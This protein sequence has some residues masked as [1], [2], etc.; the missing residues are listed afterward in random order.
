[1]RD[2]FTK[3]LAAVY[4]QYLAPTTF[5]KA[6]FP[7][8][9]VPTKLISIEVERLGEK[10]A[11]DV[12]RGTEGNRNTF[13]K[14]TE[15][16]FEPPFYREYF[17]ATE[18]DVYD[19]VLG[20]QLA[21]LPRPEMF[22]MLTKTVSEKLSKLQ[23][24]IERAYELQRAQV[25]LDG[26]VT[27]ETDTNIDY[28]R[29]AASK[30]VTTDGAIFGSNA[31]YWNTSIDPI[32]QLEI[33]AHF[34]RT[35]GRSGSSR[36]ALICGEG[37]LAALLNNSD[38]QS[39][40]DNRRYNLDTIAAPVRNAEGSAY[41]GSITVGSYVCDLWTYPQY[42]DHPDTGTSTAYISDEKVIMIPY[43][44]SFIMRH[45][46][47]PQL[48]GDPGQLPRQGEYVISDYVDQRRATHEF[49]ICSAGLAIPLGV[50]R[51]WTAQVIA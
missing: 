21:G 29:K 51:I 19:Q 47:V 39:R 45:A 30:V 38:F 48:V 4:S 12:L 40:T 44:P 26:I 22:G 3:S 43:N 15:K 18:L 34:L 46:A 20:A 31:G 1:M 16:A 5:L 49:D 23:D 50:D 41:H 10:V 33:G 11:V 7:S 25:L 2:Q 37:A 27:V 8:E 42:Y 28:K 13:S 24:K 32:A 36:F 9:T 14:S 17:D 35:V 6:F